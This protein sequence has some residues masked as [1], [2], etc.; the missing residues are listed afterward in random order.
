MTTEQRKSER[1]TA[2]NKPVTLV[3]E[4]LKNFFVSEEEKVELVNISAAGIRIRISGEH[5]FKKGDRVKV[6]IPIKY[7]DELPIVRGKITNTSVGDEGI[8]L[9]MVCE[10]ENKEDDFLLAEMIREVIA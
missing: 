6:C 10:I 8:E 9:G 1:H 5:P 3:R 4:T 7:T 2:Q